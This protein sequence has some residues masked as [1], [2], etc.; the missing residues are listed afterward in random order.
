MEQLLK[1]LNTQWR[2]LSRREAVAVIAGAIAMVFIIWSLVVLEPHRENVNLLQQEIQQVQAQISAERARMQQLQEEMQRD[3][4]SEN[5]LLLEQYLAQSKQ[6]D[7]ELAQAAVQIIDVREMVKLLKEMLARQSGLKFVSLENKP[8]KPEFAEKSKQ[9]EA[10]GHSDESIT[11][12]RHSV[13]L[14]MEGSYSSL[15]AYLQELEK[16]P[17]QFFWQ[18]IE[19]ETQSYPQALITLEVYTLGL[20]EGLIGV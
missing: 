8:A 4:D 12:Y 14:Q 17:W 2:R 1:T 10:T 11:I 15:Q 9:A 3:P 20:R 5:K 19:L 6:L 18:G 16:L 7:A 13:V